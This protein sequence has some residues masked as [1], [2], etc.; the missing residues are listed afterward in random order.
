MRIVD[1]QRLAFA[2]EQRYHLLGQLDDLERS[3]LLY[4][5][6]VFLPADRK[7]H[8]PEHRP[9]LIFHRGPPS[10]P[11]NSHGRTRR[12]QASHYLPKVSP[13]TVSRSI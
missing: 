4:T 1:I 10:S 7:G 3:I 6:A 11:D 2:L 9:K 12:F 5:E 8:F 13:W